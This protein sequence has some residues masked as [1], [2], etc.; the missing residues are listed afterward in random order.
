VDEVCK[1]IRRR[2]YCIVTN[3]GEPMRKSRASAS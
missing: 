3:G 2:G 1:K